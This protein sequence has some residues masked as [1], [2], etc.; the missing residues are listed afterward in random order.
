ML[1]VTAPAAVKK[2]VTTPQ[3]NAS[4]KMMTHCWHCGLRKRKGMRQTG[5]RAVVTMMAV[6]AVMAP[7]TQTATNK[8]MAHV[9]DETRLASKTTSLAPSD[10]PAFAW[11][12]TVQLRAAMTMLVPMRA[13]GT[14]TPTT[15]SLVDC[16]PTL[17]VIRTTR[18]PYVHHDGIAVPTWVVTRV[19]RGRRISKPCTRGILFTNLISPASGQAAVDRK[20]VYLLS[21]IKKVTTRRKLCGIHSRARQLST[22]QHCQPFRWCACIDLWLAC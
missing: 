15:K 22:E 11:P 5:T 19:V 12:K 13:Q 6:V 7:T 21:M 16:L 1:L 8:V 20:V 2:V 9:A 17:A 3:P 4:S 18:L 14:G 10:L